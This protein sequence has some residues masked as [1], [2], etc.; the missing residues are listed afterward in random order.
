MNKK[1]AFYFDSSACTGCKACQ[2]SCKDRHGLEVGA[3]WRRVYEIAGG[4]WQQTSDAWV[5]DVFVYHLSLACNHCDKPI[6]AEV[7]PTGAIT[8][9]ADGI[10]LLEESKCIGCKYCSWACPYGALQ[11]NSIRG[12]MTKCDFCVEDIDAGSS[13]ACVAAC[14]MRA[15]EFGDQVEMEAK[16]GKVGKIFPLPESQLTSPALVITPHRDITH[17]QKRPVSIANRE[18][19]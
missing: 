1:F 14:P 18:E 9:R 7:C 8:R 2:V 17:T 19:V 5:S 3:L 12:I 11:Y 16:Y 10:V 4:D 15:L 13:P 6:C